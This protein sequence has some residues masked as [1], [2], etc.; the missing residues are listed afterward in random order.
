M[1]IQ[2]RD[3]RNG[4]W[5]W[6]HKQIIQEHAPKI[7]AVGVLVYSFLACLVDKSQACFPSQKY[8]AEKL[9]YSRAT[10]SETI[11]VLESS[12]LIKIERRSRYHLVYS[13]LKVRCQREFTPETRCKAEETQMSNRGNSDV[14]YGDT[15][16]NTLTRI[17]NT[18]NNDRI[19]TGTVL[20]KFRPKSKE[21]LLAWDIAQSL[22][23]EKNLGLYISYCRK[24]PGDII[25]RAFGETK[26]ISTEKIKKSRG[27]LFTYLVKKYSNNKKKL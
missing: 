9:G 8:M 7:K 19:K 4:D 21:E 15:N 25:W 2:I 23:D 3:L 5:Y 18:D 27:A 16:D 13:L 17:Y 10:I 20:K 1:Q 14:N 12:G 6:I 11:R 22:D 26:E 24:Y